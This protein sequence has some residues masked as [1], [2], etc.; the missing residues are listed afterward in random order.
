MHA[1]GLPIALLVCV[2][3]MAGIFQAPRWLAN[4]HAEERSELPPVRVIT[5]PSPRLP[6]VKPRDTFGLRSQK[7]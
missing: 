7:Q 3:L 4:R 1:I 5:P 6:R 2:R